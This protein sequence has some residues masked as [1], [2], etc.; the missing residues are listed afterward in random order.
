MFSGD[1]TNDAVA[2]TQAIIRVYMNEGTDVAKSAANIILIRSSLSSILIVVLVSRKSF[3]IIIFDFG[4]S[5]VYS[6][7]AILLAAGAFVNTR[8]QP[9]FAGLGELVSVLSVVVVG[10]L[11]KWAKI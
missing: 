10:V 5:F 9:E 4:W 11:L 1:G 6:L 3:H 2:L 8:F 7:F